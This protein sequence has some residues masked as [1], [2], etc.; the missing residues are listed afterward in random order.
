MAAEPRYV[1]WDA[2]C[3]LHYINESAEHIDTLQGILTEVEN[4]G[5]YKIITST[6]TITEVAHT[7]QERLNRVLDDAELSRIDRIFLDDSVV[8][9]VEFSQIIARRARDVMRIGLTN[10]L[11]KDP[12]DCIH[13]ASAQ[14]LGAV[15][16]HTYDKSLWDYSEHL[17]IKV[18]EPHV[19]QFGLF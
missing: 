10:H 7:E 12:R 18:C 19:Q 16:V 17:G 4:S 2:N 14:F 3:F 9:L 11:R 15:E 6:L 8:L 5:D 13:L 1:Y